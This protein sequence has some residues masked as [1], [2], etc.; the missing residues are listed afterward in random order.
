MGLPVVWVWTH[1]S[2]GLGEDGPTHQPVEHYAALR[3]IPRLW[4]IRPGDANE[5][6]HAWH[7]ALERADG[8]VA[9]LLSRQNIAVLDREGEGLGAASELERGGY[10]LWDSAGGGEGASS[11]HGAAGGAGG[12]PELILI[13]TGAEVGPTLA[14]GR[15]LAGE[16][17]GVRVV[18]MPCM[19]LFEA[20]PAAY[21]EA[22]LPREVSARLAVEPGATM[23]WWKWV[24]T[25]GDVLG[26]DRFGASAP[27]ATVLEKLG[28]GTENIAARARALLGD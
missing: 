19:E 7:V 23:S 26:L 28:F 17:Y 14:A 25:S 6:A 10:V 22:V 15:A 8:P 13:A 27:G 2:V 18:S 4:V 20:Q 9:L 21:R 24:G 12:M 5:T 3:A 11:V 1:D 16:G